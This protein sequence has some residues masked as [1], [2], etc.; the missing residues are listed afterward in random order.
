MKAL[1]KAGAFLLGLAVVLTGLSYNVL[2]AQELEKSGETGSRALALETRPVDATVTVIRMSGPVDLKLTQGTTPSMNVR[3][4]QRYLAKIVTT[5]VGN[6]LTVDTRG[7]IINTHR[8][9]VV[10]LVLPAIEELRVMGSGDAVVNGF[11]ADKLHL[12]LNGS[13]DVRVNGSA[14]QLIAS[15]NGSGDLSWEGTASEGVELKLHGSGDVTV[16][17][18]TRDLA[19]T[20][21]GSGDVQARHFQSENASLSLMGSGD[22]H[23]NVKKTVTAVLHGSGDVIISGNPQQRSVST[24]G[25]GEVRWE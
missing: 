1:L 21:M 2:R 6:T 20:L 14:R 15:L 16:R 10:E 4:E 23:V 22:A 11:A 19:A 3:A 9:M 13:G 18:S 17:G 12:Q 24:S 7:V 25:S 8:P 5:Q